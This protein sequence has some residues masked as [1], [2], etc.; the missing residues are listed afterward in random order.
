MRQRWNDLLFAHYPI[1][2]TVM[3]PLIPKG[4]QLDTCEGQAW[5]GVVPFWMDRVQT[6]TLGSHTLSIPT[7]RTFSELN[8]RTYVRSPRT[9]LAGVYFFSLDCSSPLA[10]LGARTLFHLPYYFASMDRHVSGTRTHY[11]SRR[12]LTRHHPAFEAT[13][14]PVGPVQRS[15][16]GSLAA[17]LTERY[18]L[19]TTSRGR[20]LRGDIHH[21]AWPL[22]PAEAT[23]AI[24]EIPAAH[25]LSI[26]ETAPLLHFSRSLDVYI[27]SLCLDR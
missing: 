3:A 21:L 1:P 5:L 25:N 27:W 14:N 23:I 16:P 12:Q 24:D 10:V 9:G 22:Q 8:L 18:C 26:P 11:R 6:R 15:S 7:T 20:V 2:P 19:F 13:F 17:F 4:L